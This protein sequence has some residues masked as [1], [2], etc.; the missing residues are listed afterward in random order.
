MLVK[1]RKELEKINLERRSKDSVLGKE[2]CEW[3]ILLIG[4]FVHNNKD[5][6]DIPNDLKAIC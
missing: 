3:I 4:F 5:V 1:M 6:L 2:E